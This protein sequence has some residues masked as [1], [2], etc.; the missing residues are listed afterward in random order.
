MCLL[1]INL[2][3]LCPNMNHFDAVDFSECHCEEVI[4]FFWRSVYITSTC[5]RIALP[6]LLQHGFTLDAPHGTPMYRDVQRHLAS[7]K[8]KI[9]WNNWCIVK[10]ELFVAN[11]CD[12]LGFKDARA[13]RETTPVCSGL[14]TCRLV[15]A[16]YSR[17]YSGASRERARITRRAQDG[18]VHMQLI[19]RPA[20]IPP[21]RL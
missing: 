16:G 5:K 13:W 17:H 9:M 11:P 19:S 10:W 7:T 3:N 2:P 14:T 8:S 15:R 21:G 1:T 18:S 4:S 6:W 20:P 12:L